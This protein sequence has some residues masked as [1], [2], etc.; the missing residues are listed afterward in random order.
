MQHTLLRVFFL[1]HLICNVCCQAVKRQGDFIVMQIG[2]YSQGLT[3]I[4]KQG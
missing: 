2:T 1:C 4:S 3:D